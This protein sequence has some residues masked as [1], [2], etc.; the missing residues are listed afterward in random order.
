MSNSS[1]KH[2][3]SQENSRDE[4]REYPG[5]GTLIIVTISLCL[6]VF[7][8][9]LVPDVPESYTVATHR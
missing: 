2:E 4:Q 8:F 9:A 3:E 6:I 1:R 7:V 5:K